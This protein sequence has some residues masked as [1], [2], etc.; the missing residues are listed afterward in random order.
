MYNSICIKYYV[1]LSRITRLTGANCAAIKR[2][3]VGHLVQVEEG[4]LRKKAEEVKQWLEK[5]KTST[6]MGG[7]SENVRI[8]YAMNLR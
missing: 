6:E 3:W 2:M 8:C 7:L 5:R 1:G 4:Q